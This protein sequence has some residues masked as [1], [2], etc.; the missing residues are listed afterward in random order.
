M[1]DAGIRSS[2]KSIV[3]MIATMIKYLYLPIIVVL[4][5]QNDLS[6][7]VEY[8][9]QVPQLVFAAQGIATTY[10]QCAGQGDPGA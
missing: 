7:Q 6:A 9:D 10:T 2:T 8:D 4:L 5:F 1:P 3:V